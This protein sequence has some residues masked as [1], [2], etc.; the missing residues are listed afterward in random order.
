MNFWSML[1]A[2]APYIPAAIAS[3]AFL[4][5]RQ[6]VMIAIFGIMAVLF[7][8]DR[9]ARSEAAQHIVDRLSTSR[10]NGKGG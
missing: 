10:R 8:S 6:T 7:A 5:S 2:I 1:T 9:A 4:L 3:I